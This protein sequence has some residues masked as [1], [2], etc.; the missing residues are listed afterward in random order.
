MS[1][2]LPK[3]IAIFFIAMFCFLFL[4][5]FFSI[6]NVFASDSIG[7]IDPSHNLAWGENFGWLNFGCTNCNIQI[8][9]TGLSGYVWSKQ[10]GWINLSPTKAG[11]TNNCFGQ[12]GGKAWS[13]RLGWIN[14]SGASID[15]NG[16]FTGTAG[17]VSDKSGRLNF[18]CTNCN[19]Q[20]DWRQCS[21]RASPAQVKINSIT[22]NTIPSITANI[23]ITNEGSVDTEYQYEW[24]V[25]TNQDDSC[26]DPNN[27][28]YSSAAK[29]ITKGADWVT[30]LNATVPTVGN[31]WFKLVVHYG[32]N[33]SVASQSFTAITS[34]SGGGSG[35]SGGGG[36]GGGSST[37]TP[38][39]VVPV[40]NKICNGADFSH[41]GVVNS[42]DFSILLYFWKTN[43]PFSNP[44]VDLNADK[45]VDSVDFS[46]LL[47]NWGKHLTNI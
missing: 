5:C 7:A 10:Y 22:D 4:F 40:N 8:T 18:D 30:D 36:G 26:G 20:T 15:F 44:C 27:I 47:Y 2:F 13:S 34:S 11:V 3:K 32:I 37:P 12:L 35:G 23:I 28:S 33:R 19:V 9:D 25:V 29:L 38:T 17:L 16:K 24:C 43:Y 39:P 46:I 6:N 14:F 21:L 41:D 31:Y 1:S 45:K 42:V